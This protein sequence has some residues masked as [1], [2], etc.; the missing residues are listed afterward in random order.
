MMCR[1]GSKPYV[2]CLR[3]CLSDIKIIWYQRLEVYVRRLH[4]LTTRRRL[5]LDTGEIWKVIGE[6]DGN[7]HVRN[8]VNPSSRLTLGW[9][10][11]PPYWGGPFVW[12]LVRNMILMT[13]NLLLTD[14]NAHMVYSNLAIRRWNKWIMLLIRCPQRCKFDLWYRTGHAGKER[15]IYIGDYQGVWCG[16]PVRAQ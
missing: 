14:V 9:V 13:V 1:D 12:I 7:Y 8:Y 6:F 10:K 16:H 5:K 2:R 11:R 4:F 3:K 15:K